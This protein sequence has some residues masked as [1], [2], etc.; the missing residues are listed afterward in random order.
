MPPV[1]LFIGQKRYSSWSLRPWIMLKHAGIDFTEKLTPVEGVGV[2]DKLLSVSP[3]G[4]VPCV[5]DADGE[6]IW[7]SLAICEWAAEHAPTGAVWP[8]DSKAR[9]FSRSI[10]AEMHSGFSDLRGLLSMHVAMQ[11]PADS[12]L[13]LP[14]RVASQVARIIEIWRSAR[15]RWGVPSSRPFLFGDFSA[16]DAMFAPVIFRFQTYRVPIDDPLAKAYYEAM[17][18]DPQM[19]QWEAAALVETVAPVEKYDAH[20][21]SLGAVR[22]SAL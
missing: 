18:A 6:L 22:R 13:P 20:L 2:N 9:M 3:S 16:A 12:P 15:A 1:E 8:T 14:P 7:D 10:A 4:L 19:R 21:L 5:R 11:L 17:L